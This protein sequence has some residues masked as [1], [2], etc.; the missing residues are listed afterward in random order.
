VGLL[1]LL[2]AS[3]GAVAAGRASMLVALKQDALAGALV[4]SA[5]YH[6]LS[7]AAL[8][9]VACTLLSQ[10]GRRKE[11]AIAMRGVLIGWVLALVVGR[12]VSPPARPDYE[13]VRRR[14]TSLRDDIES[15][16]RKAPAGSVACI[17]N[18]RLYLSS[19]FPGTLGIFILYHRSDEFEGRPV[20]FT[21]SDPELLASRLPGSR[22]ASLL[23]PTG[24]CPPQIPH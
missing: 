8:A 11:A 14:V 6:Y 13:P 12:T 2:A 23:L 24:S 4:H 9:L 19:G 22:A 10:A 21:S 3:Y 15:E 16:I 7:Q 18:Q 20:Y 5:R 1:L 17:P